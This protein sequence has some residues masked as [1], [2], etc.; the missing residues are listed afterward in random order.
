M[1]C[2]VDQEKPGRTSTLPPPCCHRKPPPF[3]C[4]QYGC[5]PLQQRPPKV[6]QDCVPCPPLTCKPRPEPPSRPPTI[7][8]VGSCPEPRRPVAYPRPSLPKIQPPRSC[9]RFCIRTT[10]EG[11][12]YFPC[13]TSD[14]P[15]CNRTCN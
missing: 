12:T 3:Y 1:S 2:L 7:C 8:I 9:V 11:S 14:L 5:P 15:N 10:C 6:R 13:Y 4:P